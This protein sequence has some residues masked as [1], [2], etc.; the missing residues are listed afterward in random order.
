MQPPFLRATG[1]LVLSLCTW[2]YAVPSLNLPETLADT[3]AKLA[4]G[5]QADILVLGDSLSFADGNYL[6]VFRSKLQATFGNAGAGYQAFS[7]WTGGALNL[8]STIG[9]LSDD[10]APYYG[11]DGL[12]VESNNPHEI[13]YLKAQSPTIEL[14]YLAQPGGG[15]F[16]PFL[17]TEQ[18]RVNLSAPISTAST[19]K[20]VRTWT[21]TDLVPGTKVYYQDAGGGTVTLLGQNNTIDNSGVRVHRAANGGW[22]VTHFLQRDPSFDEQLGMVNPDLV[23][24]MLGANDAGSTMAPEFANNLRQLIDRVHMTVEDAEILL[25]SPY[26]ISPAKGVNDHIYQRVVQPE[27]ALAEELGV[28]F[29]NLHD[30]A[31]DFSYLVSKGYLLDGVHQ[32]WAGGDYFGDIMFNAFM[33]NGASLVPEPAALTLLIPAMVLMR[34]RRS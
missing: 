15:L 9:L 29:L 26:D 27:I 8:G 2:V 10:V 6:P 4:A 16:Q 18:G 17:N 24:I 31:G 28:G 21:Y 1:V 11:M 33:T 20:E 13:G 25:V 7:M 3:K 22:R 14:Q 34:R 32:T 30:Y 23:M 19:T 12:W 5:G